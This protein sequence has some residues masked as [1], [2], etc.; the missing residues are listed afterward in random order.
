MKFPVSESEIL[1]ALYSLGLTEGYAEKNRADRP[2]KKITVHGA[3]IK[4]V[5]IYVEKMQSYLNN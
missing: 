2:Y 3:S 5:N 4:T 1:R